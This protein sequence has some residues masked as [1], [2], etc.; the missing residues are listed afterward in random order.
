MLLL[1]QALLSRLNKNAPN[2]KK[3]DIE[4]RTRVKDLFFIYPLSKTRISI[5]IFNMIQV[6]GTISYL[7]KSMFSLIHKLNILNK[8]ILKIT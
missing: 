3:K 8:H 5:I 6:K 7:K 4:K 1:S 2:N